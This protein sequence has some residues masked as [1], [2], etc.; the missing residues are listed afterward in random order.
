LPAG[1]STENNLEKWVN[2][3][4]LANISYIGALSSG[5]AYQ[6]LLQIIKVPRGCEIVA[7]E[8]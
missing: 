6:K 4:G 8:P 3:Q 5:D 1:S 7:D 2:G